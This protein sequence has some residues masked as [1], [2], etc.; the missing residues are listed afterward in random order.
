LRGV[1]EA[2]GLSLRETAKRA[3]LDPAHLMKVERYEAGLSI[4]SLVRLAN[5]LGLHE[6]ERS[7]WPYAPRSA[8]ARK[9]SGL[10][11]TRAKDNHGK[12]ITA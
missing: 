11:G 2:Q 12:N 9:L 7:L 10:N 5:V 3:G 1:R 6:V 4:E 8:R